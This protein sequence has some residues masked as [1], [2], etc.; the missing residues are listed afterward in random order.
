M[1]GFLEDI[2]I[3]VELLYQEIGTFKTSINISKLLSQKAILVCPS[4]NSDFYSHSEEI[5][6]NFKKSRDKNVICFSLNAS[7]I[8]HLSMIGGHC[9]MRNMITHRFKITPTK[10]LIT[11]KKRNFT[12]EKS[13]KHYLK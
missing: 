9:L 4:N 11:K 12:V 3:E 2:F 10:Y 7:D 13:G 1:C 5:L 8:E 6:S